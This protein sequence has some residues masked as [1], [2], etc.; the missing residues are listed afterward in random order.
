MTPPLRPF[1]A[2]GGVGHLIELRVRGSRRAH[3]CGCRLRCDRDGDQPGRGAGTGVGADDGIWRWTDVRAGLEAPSVLT[4]EAVARP[5]TRRQVAN[6][7][8]LTLTTGTTRP[9][10]F[11]NGRIHTH[12][13]RNRAAASSAGASP[14]N[15][16]TASAVRLRTSTAMR[17]GSMPMLRS[18]R[19]QLPAHPHAA[20]NLRSCSCRRRLVG[21]T[22]VG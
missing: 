11:G 12:R 2:P 16:Q 8:P 6:L 10:P 5:P 17:F 22:R 21:P 9:L 3:R 18:V 13:W 14:R 15:H 19:R 1:R 4:A 7:S 20:P